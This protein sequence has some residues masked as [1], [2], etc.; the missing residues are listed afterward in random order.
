MEWDENECESGGCV[1]VL[2]WKFNWMSAQQ[3]QQ[4]KTSTWWMP[5]LEF[6][7]YFVILHK[8]TTKSTNLYEN[9][10]R[11][12]TMTATLINS[13]HWVC[14]TVSH[15]KLWALSKLRTIKMAEAKIDA[16]HH[17]MDRQV[18]A[19][20]DGSTKMVRKCYYWMEICNFRDPHHQQ[21]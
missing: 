17:W 18:E 19:W 20:P 4:Q 11:T 2:D 13:I 5:A 3:Q 14:V 7:L 15:Y 8:I 10:I 1:L 6:F 16:H 21:H 9:A 12:T